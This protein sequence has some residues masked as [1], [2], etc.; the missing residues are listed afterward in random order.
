MR[1]KNARYNPIAFAV[2]CFTFLQVWPASV[3]FA[4]ET[5]RIRGLVIDEENRNPLPG[6]S[7]KILP[8]GLQ[9]NTDL[10]G[11]F[12]FTGLRGTT[13]TIVVS[14]MGY[15]ESRV[16]VLASDLDELIVIGLTPMTND[17]D[18]IIVTGSTDGQQKA[19]NQQR[20]ADNI[21]NIISAD[22][23]GRFPDLNVA[24]ALQRVPG[25][26]I[27][28]DKGEGS[29]IALRGTPQHF[30]TVQINGEQLP[31][32]QQGGSRN[33]ALDLIPSDQL[34]SIEIIKAPTPD[35]DG[36]AIGGIVNLRTPTANRLKWSGKA[37]GS[38]G[39]NDIS[40]G[41]NGIGK[42]RADKRF[43]SSESVPEGKIGIMLSGSYYSS[44]NSEDRMNAVWTG[45]PQPVSELDSEYI[46]PENYGFRKTMNERERTGITGTFDY[47]PDGYNHLVLN[48]MYNRRDDNDIQNRIR[49]DFDRGP[50]EWVNFQQVDG[51]RV[52]RD[53]NLWNEE[54]NN[55]NIS[56]Q[57]YHTLQSWQIDWA[58]SYVR[59]NRDFSSTRGDFSYDNIDLKITDE[60]GIF[61][62]SPVFQASDPNLDLHNPLLYNDFRRYEE[63]LETTVADNLVFRADVSKQMS[64]F[65]SPFTLK[66]GG[67]YRTQSNSKFR[68]NQV[69]A[70]FD[71]NGVLNLN[72]AYTRVIGTTEPTNFLFRNYGFGPMI[73]KN[74]FDDYIHHNR[75]LL[76]EAD[77]AWDARRLSLNDTYDAYEDIYAGYA[78]GRLQ[79]GNLMVLT[80][81]RM[82]SNAVSYDAFEVYRSGTNVESS[83]IAG[84]NDFVFL[85]PHLHMKYALN[86]WTNIRFSVLRNYARP[87]F[88]DVVPF[89]NYDVDA[90]ALQLGNPDLTPS[91]AWNVDAMFEHYF[92]NA[93]VISIG[94]FYKDIDR[95][96]FTSL[97][98]SLPQAF[99]GYPE[100]QGFEFRQE[101][102]GKR[103]TV[104]GV[105]VNIY[106][107]LDF[108]PGILK[109]LAV[110]ANYTFAYSNAH[111]QDRADIR[112]P[113][114]ADHTFNAMLSFN[115]KDF[116]IRGS[117]N[118]NGTYA[119]S[120][121]SQKQDDIFQ[122]YRTQL[123][124]NASYKWKKF[125]IY[126]EWI[127]LLNEPSIRY[128][129]DESRLSRM[130]FYGYGARYGMSYSF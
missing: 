50:T 42:L 5:I 95:F 22:V 113:G 72:E 14:Y 66:F 128:Q 92:P 87:N 20:S 44:N 91:S 120:I 118:Y 69:L 4:Q 52:R 2:I 1:I 48:Y 38:L 93:G 112:L 19:L 81:L 28:R 97:I 61:T 116:T 67:K 33:E 107:S 125:R 64:L 34:A 53:I 16:D 30:T 70:F 106:R 86:E 25:I 104:A 62:E 13:K 84:G 63:D 7:V 68:N 17:L 35:L 83:P 40:G 94:A 100:T 74:R 121:A 46:L 103:A 10:N 39:Y 6:G 49:Y 73:D 129:G 18:E 23:M 98:N 102:N 90:L 126:T 26:N 36:D 77:D 59:S 127:N 55:H 105:E 32:V 27:Q 114:Q 60:K 71:P 96:Q 15:Q 8:E 54:K 12:V 119:E 51:A 41:L 43:M 37:E 76:T 117:V 108:L 124:L 123:D 122:K 56:L 99:P 21:K 24:E 75:F 89:V 29:T 3:L 45:Y 79:L 11:Q 115:Y 82:E 57:G 101:Q 31:S 47:K 58:A 80:G 111:T 110:N 85:L 88:V 109:S 9:S 78:M 130:S 65:D